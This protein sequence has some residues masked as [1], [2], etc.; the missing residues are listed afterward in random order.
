VQEGD[1]STG[2]AT[3]DAMNALQVIVGNGPFTSVADVLDQMANAIGQLLSDAGSPEELLFR[4]VLVATVCR[5]ATR[6]DPGVAQRILTSMADLATASAR[7][8][9]RIVRALAARVGGVGASTQVADGRVASTLQF[10]QGTFCDPA[11]CLAQAARRVHTS[12][13]YLAHLLKAHTGRSF[14]A[15][16]RARRVTEAISLLDGSWLSVK[17]IAA[18][19]GYHD[20]HSLT[21]DFRRTY[22]IAPTR[23][24]TTR[25]LGEVRGAKRPARP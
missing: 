13:W 17:E 18:R 2:L 12:P 3:V 23:W 25:A 6:C 19:V 7:E 21:R 24:R 20:A 1:A 9:P 16:L 8:L 22:G 10:I 15:H 11:L 5:L 14:T 4:G